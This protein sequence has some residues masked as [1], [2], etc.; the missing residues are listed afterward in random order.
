MRQDHA[1]LCLCYKG[2]T[3]RGKNNKINTDENFSI[4]FGIMYYKAQTYC[5]SKMSVYY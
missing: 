3:C 5:W 2:I 4:Y 1:T